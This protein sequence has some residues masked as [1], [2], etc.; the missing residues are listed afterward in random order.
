MDDL[1]V[2]HRG[3]C[4]T[5]MEVE[6]VGL[7]VVIPDRCLVLQLNDTL[8]VLI[9]PACKQRLMLLGKQP[10]LSHAQALVL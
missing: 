1:E 7:R 8:C 9:L 3:L 4:D 2:L 10:H 5:P 6:Y